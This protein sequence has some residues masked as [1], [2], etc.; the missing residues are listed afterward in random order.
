MERG[1]TGIRK[2]IRP[3]SLTPGKT[4]GVLPIVGLLR[5]MMAQRNEGGVKR[6][7][8]D[9]G[10]RDLAD[11]TIKRTD[12]NEQDY[13]ESDQ[14]SEKVKVNKGKQIRGSLPNV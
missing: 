14:K 4:I 6:T 9:W 7:C 5:G 2:H 13:L 11:E 3:W 10:V 12:K 8:A 1:C